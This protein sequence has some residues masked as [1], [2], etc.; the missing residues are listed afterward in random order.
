[1]NS[2]QQSVHPSSAAASQDAAQ[3]EMDEANRLGMMYGSGDGVPQDWEQARTW[4]RKAADRGH[5]N[6]QFNLAVI[7]SNGRRAQDYAH[8]LLWYRKAAHQGHAK[9]QFNLGLMYANGQGVQQDQAQ[10]LAWYTE[11]AEL[12]R[13][14]A[15]A[16]D[17]LRLHRR[18]LL[19]IVLV[20]HAMFAEVY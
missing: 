8:A 1:M 2:L 11:A 6:A 4:F 7:Y 5:A 9:A 10:A 14:R 15:L 20:G 13:L 12:G 17:E 16:V 3:A 18:A 19:G